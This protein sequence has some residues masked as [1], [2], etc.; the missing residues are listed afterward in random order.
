MWWNAVKNR[1][2]NN[3]AVFFLMI[4]TVVFGCRWKWLL[5]I[6][7][8]HKEAVKTGQI[9]CKKLSQKEEDSLHQQNWNSS[10]FILTKT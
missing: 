7:K 4:K 10:E 6:S 8:C 1:L 3:S 5:L 9:V 2:K